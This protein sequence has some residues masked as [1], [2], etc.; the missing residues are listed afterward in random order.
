M[1]YGFVLWVQGIESGLIPT[2]T[3][4]HIQV[5]ISQNVVKDTPNCTLACS[6]PDESLCP[7]TDRNQAGSLQGVVGERGEGEKC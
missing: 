6:H 2:E 4:T 1:V 7:R 3:H 5:P